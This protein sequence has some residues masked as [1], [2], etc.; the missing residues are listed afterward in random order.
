MYCPVP[1]QA[2]RVIS[3]V[4]TQEEVARK[5]LRPRK[6]QCHLAYFDLGL[7]G[8]LLAGMITAYG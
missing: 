4:L 1:V 5:G 8:R 7:P 2:R 6:R 3:G